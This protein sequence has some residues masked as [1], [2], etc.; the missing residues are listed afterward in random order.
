MPNGIIIPFT[1]REEIKC[2]G[3]V[4]PPFF[5]EDLTFES[6]KRIAGEVDIWEPHPNAIGVENAMFMI[7]EEGI[8]RG[9]GALNMWATMI[10]ADYH[11]S[12]KHQPPTAEV[13]ERMDKT[14]DD[15]ADWCV[16]MARECI[17]F[18][19]AVLLGDEGH[20][21]TPSAL[22]DF[23]AAAARG[24]VLKGSPG[25]ADKIRTEALELQKALGMD[26]ARS[27]NLVK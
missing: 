15:W 5:M 14:E 2:L 26:I 20:E 4:R 1:H 3:S 9:E 25:A 11:D 7:D 27:F 16:R 12:Q 10:V 13:L 6:S 21:M 19:S 18:G 22:I 23:Y 8:N 17:I 24:A